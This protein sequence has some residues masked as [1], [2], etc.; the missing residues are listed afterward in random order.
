MPPLNNRFLENVDSNVG[1]DGLF[2][3]AYV[4][5]VNAST[6]SLFEDMF[7]IGG[8][9]KSSDLRACNLNKPS[10]TK[11]MLLEW[12]ETFVYLLDEFSIPLMHFA[13]DRTEEL[14]ELKTEKIGDQKKIIELQDQLID[15]KEEELLSVRKTVESELKSYSSAVQNTCS[16]ALAPR[17]LAAAVKAVSDKEDRSANIIVFGVPEEDDEVVDSKV[18][19]LLEHLG[20]KPKVTKCR[21]I[22]LRKSATPRPISFSVQ[23]SSTV[24]QIL[25]K[26]RQLKEI[27]GYK[28]IYLSPDRTISRRG[29]LVR[30]L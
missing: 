17:K 28:S 19:D 12:L 27:E 22:G 26:A 15:K 16:E 20:E 3:R 11:A 24:F 4:K 29:S 7:K 1:E 30:N 21:R 25:Q 2:N 18:T 5:Q 8:V 23:S 10:I 6:R 14:D 9:K 13:A